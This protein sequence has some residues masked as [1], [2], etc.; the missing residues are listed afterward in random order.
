MTLSKHLSVE[1]LEQKYLSK[2]E[3][4]SLNHH[5]EYISGYDANKMIAKTE[6]PETSTP[7]IMVYKTL[8]EELALDGIPTLNLASFVNTH[9][10]DVQHKLISENIVKNL[11]DNDEYP[12]LIEFQNR[13]V[14]I[15]SN[16]WHAPSTTNDAGER[17]TNSIGTATTGSSEAIMLAGLALKKR[18]QEKRRAQGK[19]AYHP[20]IIMASCAQVALEKFA[21][22]FDVENRLISI[23]EG[24]N[25]LIN[26][27]DIRKN[28]DENT[29]GIFVI[30]GSTFTGAFEP[31]ERISHLLDEVEKETGLDIRIHVDGASGG[32]VAPFVYPHLKWD[33]EV[34]R[35]DSINTSG[36]KFGM[37]SAGLGWVIWKDADLLPKSLK[38]SLDYL[39]GVE[40]TFGLNFSR[41]GFPVILQYYNFLALGREGYAKIHDASLS[42]ARLL[43]NV[44]KDSGYF[45]LLSVIHK[46]ITAEQ[47]KLYYTR[48]HTIEHSHKEQAIANESYEP[49][50][51]VVAFRFSKQFRE[52]YPEI[53][54]EL[55]S[56]L[57]RNKGYIVPNYRLPPEEGDVEVLRVVVRGSFSV[58]LLDKLVGAITHTVEVLV[59]ACKHVRSIKG[60]T[61]NI[62]RGIKEL[63]IQI[64]SAGQAS[65]NEKKEEK[66][67]PEKKHYS[68]C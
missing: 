31:V 43:S 45:E 11:A 66:V 6:I 64:A 51:P 7:G 39:G 49:G 28:I 59:D 27:D 17:I 57:L 15:L 60:G 12:S 20:N 32:F 38:F 22:Y 42:N 23:T 56:S 18:W 58:N 40:E 3:T 19:D 46:P 30:L 68:R 36:H 2:T 37:T 34:P 9:I 54:Q 8:N 48:E 55:I 53:P 21:T 52:E 16:L 61:E 13:C 25:H 63:L 10:N 47:K 26:V 62:D 35:V 50:L 4:I 33:F 44:L 29:I 24:S 65:L 41:P 1:A 14:T 5:E 67:Q